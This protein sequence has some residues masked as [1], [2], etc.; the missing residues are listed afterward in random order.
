MARYENIL[1]TI[2]NTPLVR[3]NRLAPPG[4]NVYVK[5]EAFNPMGSVKDRMARAVIE[6]AEL[7]GQLRLGQ[8]VIEATSG[9][10]GIGLAMVCAQKGYPLVVTMA[11]SFSI[12]RRKLLRFLGAKVVLTPAAEKGTGMLAKAVELAEA[13]G[14]FLCRQFENE[15][16]AD[17]HSRTTAQ[18]ILADFAG[19]RLDYWVSGFGTGGTVKGVAR[20]LKEVRPETKVIAAE[21]DNA[22]VLGSGIP[23]RRDATGNPLESHP[24]FRPHLMQGWAPDFISRLTEDAVAAGHIDEIVPVAGAE[25]LRLARELALQEGIFVGT[26]SGGTL[27]AALEVARR[28]PPG[29]NIVCMLPDT[30]ERY[31]TTPLFEHIGEEMTP[32][33]LA[34][35]RS[36]P[37]CRFDAP[38]PPPAPLE[39]ARVEID[40]EVAR[41]V[42]DLIRAEPVVLFSLEWCEFC[43]S[44]RK[45]FSR[46]GI[47]YRSVDLD[48]VEY[49]KNDLGGKIRAVLAK[50]TGAKTIPQLFVGADHVGGCTDVFNAWRDGSLQ[51]RLTLKGIQ[52]DVSAQIDPYSLLPKWQQPRKTA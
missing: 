18:E 15:A 20:V 2:G 30:G 50:R 29:T 33:E 22:Q 38:P 35:S 36:T 43:W 37:S 24:R 26:S 17:V 14:W 32:D 47:A 52:Y 8:T 5:I 16:N 6:R 23:Q 34:I 41:F 3:L 7:T 11:E 51:R 28:S 46:V 49:Q 39:S 1:E 13:H 31:L 19:E 27:A 44:V 42:D 25:A 45:F 40:A 4:V 48:S 12:E 10:T 9:N 21:P